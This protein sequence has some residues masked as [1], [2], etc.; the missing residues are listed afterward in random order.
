MTVFLHEGT[1]LRADMGRRA[2]GEPAGW[3]EFGDGEFTL[4]GSPA[5]LLGV[6]PELVRLAEDAAALGR[7]ESELEPTA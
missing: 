2:P 4:F 5:A 1:E 3:L 7:G 6:G